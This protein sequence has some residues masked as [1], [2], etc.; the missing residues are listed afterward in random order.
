VQ[1]FLNLLRSL[2]AGSPE[3]RIIH[4]SALFV[5]WLRFTP[6]ELLVSAKTMPL[7]RLSLSGYLPLA[8]GR[9]VLAGFVVFTFLAPAAAWGNTFTINSEADL[10]TA[11]ATAQNGDTVSFKANVILTAGDLPIVQKN[12]TILGNNFTLSGNNQFRGLF[13]AAFQPGTSNPAPVTVTIRD[14]T[15][16]N[17]K[18]RGGDGG[19]GGLS[20][21]GGGLGG[22]GRAGGGGLGSGATG[23]RVGTQ[24]RRG[25]RARCGARR[26][27]A[28]RRLRERRRVFP[29][30]RWWGCW[31]R[32]GRLLIIWRQWWFWGWWRARQLLERFWRP[33]GQWRFWRRRRRLWWW[34]WRW[35]LRFEGRLRRRQ[36]RRRCRCRFGRCSIRHGGGQLEPGRP[37]DSQRQHRSAGP[38]RCG[39]GNGQAFGSGFFLQGNGTLAFPPGVGQLQR[40]SDAIADQS[41]SGGTAANGTDGNWSVVKS[42]PGR[43][44]LAGANTYTGG[45][46]ISADTL[47]A[48][49][50]GAFPAASAF[51]VASGAT[52]DLNGFDQTIGN[53]SGGGAV[54]LGKGKLDH[55]RRQQLDNVLRRDFRLR[56]SR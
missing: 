49:A 11:L 22:N 4:N 9:W 51:A 50:V 44:I 18:A 35:R 36:R 54:A 46:T 10:R 16:S 27:W 48:G 1:D 6:L 40:V 29:R 33:W 56:W 38:R 25:D 39:A 13:I 23:G 21:G 15:I 24:W 53:L 32:L 28:V 55:R 17:A 43:L 45:T 20:G 7:S 37:A 19:N 5:S 14:L 26:R 52:L 41:G 42:G 8:P 34:E 47:A 3:K 2:V 31:R 30:R 12:V